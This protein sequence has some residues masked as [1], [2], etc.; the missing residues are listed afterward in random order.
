MALAR[1]TALKYINIKKKNQNRLINLLI[2]SFICFFTSLK[3]G[4]QA[5]KRSLIEDAKFDHRVIN[6]EPVNEVKLIKIF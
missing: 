6:A 3:Y 5:R 2:Y 1:A 4:Y